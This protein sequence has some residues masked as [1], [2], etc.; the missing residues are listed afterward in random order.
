M[1]GRELNRLSKGRNRFIGSTEEEVG[2]P[3]RPHTVEEPTGVCRPPLGRTDELRIGKHLV[4]PTGS[5]GG[6]KEHERRSK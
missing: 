3:C 6:T 5:Q 4:D 1:P 2:V